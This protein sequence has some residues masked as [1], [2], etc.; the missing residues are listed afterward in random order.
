MESERSLM[1][2]WEL[3][4][5]YQLRGASLWRLGV[6]PEFVYEQIDEIF[7]KKIN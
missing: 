1:K 3:V 6:I 4:D 7:S 5:K 2:K